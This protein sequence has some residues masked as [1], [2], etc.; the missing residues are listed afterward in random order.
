MF[1]LEP[2]RFHT[3]KFDTQEERAAAAA[4]SPAERQ[5]MVENLLFEYALFTSVS[6]GIKRFHRPVDGGT[7]GC[8]AIGG[9]LGESRSGKSYICQYYKAGFPVHV[10]EEGERYPVIYLEARADWTPHHTAEQIFMKT[11]AKSVPS[12]KTAALITAACR[13]LL[14]AGTELVIF[15]DAHFLLLES[16]GWALSCFRSLVKGIA[17]LR[18][19]NVLLAGLPGLQAF[20]EAESQLCG[21]GDFPHWHVQPLRWDIDTEREQFTLLLHGIA[22]RLP[23]QQLSDFADPEVVADF[24]HTSGGVI[25]RVMN[26]ICDAALRAINDQAGCV[27]AHHLTAAA[28]LRLRTGDTYIPFQGGRRG[29]AA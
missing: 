22:R 1:A 4:L 9:V 21:R 20:I 2:R 8:G 14:K 23:F 15:D 5:W 17:D 7:H 3:A 18:S 24:Y 27:M 28:T 12:M 10:A 25:G 13:R 11:G 19:C 26:I 29:V 16:K 6:D